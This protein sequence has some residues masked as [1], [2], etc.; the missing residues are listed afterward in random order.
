MKLVISYN[1]AGVHTL[2]L[3]EHTQNRHYIL[4]ISDASYAISTVAVL[5]SSD[6]PP[7]MLF[8]PVASTPI[9]LPFSSI[10]TP[11]CSFLLYKTS[12]AKTHIHHTALF[13]TDV[14]LSLPDGIFDAFKAVCCKMHFVKLCQQCAIFF[15]A[16]LSSIV[17]RSSA[18][19]MSFPDNAYTCPT[20][21]KGDCICVVIF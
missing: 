19:K 12:T 14:L 16:C 20:A 15:F 17:D 7:V 2:L 10:L 3:Y 8:S 4:S 9:T 21:F 18:Y 6:G 5:T 1:T 11:I 13:L